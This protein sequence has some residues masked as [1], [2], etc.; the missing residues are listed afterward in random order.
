MRR[1]ES[2]GIPYDPGDPLQ[3]QIKTQEQ[4]QAKTTPGRIVPELTTT[5]EAG[6]RPSVYFVVYPDSAS[7]EKPKL[8]VEF[9]VD[10]EVVA[11]RVSDLGPVDPTGAVPLIVA[12]ATHPGDC[13]LRVTALQGGDFST[14]TLR[15]TIPRQ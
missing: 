13:E 9:R 7:A 2:T 6:A 5:L 12:A 14:Q 10:G 4:S 1:V 11:K 3:L 8:W 15:Y